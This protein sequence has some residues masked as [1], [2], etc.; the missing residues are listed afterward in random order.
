MTLLLHH[1]DEYSCSETVKP[2]FSNPTA[3]INVLALGTQFPKM[4]LSSDICTAKIVMSTMRKNGINGTNILKSG[5][6]DSSYA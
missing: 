5:S 3:F 1:H 6:E 2:R 4:C